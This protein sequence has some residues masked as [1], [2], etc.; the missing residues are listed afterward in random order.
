[1]RRP[2]QFLFAFTSCVLILL[3]ITAC[4][5]ITDAGPTDPPGAPPDPSARVALP[6]KPHGL[7]MLNPQGAD[8]ASTFLTPGASGFNAVKGATFQVHW[9]DIEPNEPGTWVFPTSLG[10]SVA[11]WQAAGKEVNLVFQAANYT[12]QSFM[13]AW[14]AATLTAA[15][16]QPRS[17]TQIRAVTAAPLGFLVGPAVGQYLLI[18]GTNT[19]LDNN[20]YPITSV[21]PSG[22]G[23][24]VTLRAPAAAT[25]AISANGSVGNPVFSCGVSTGIPAFWGPNFIHAWENVIDQVKAHLDDGS[26]GYL[27]IGMGLGGENSPVKDITACASTM[28]NL[29]FTTQPLPWPQY[30]TDPSAWESEVA[31]PW[32]MFQDTLI[33]YIAS[34]Q[35]ATPISF[36]LSPIVYAPAAEVD[37]A[38]PDMT[39]ALAVPAGFGIG[40]QGWRATD[41]VSGPCAG[42]YCNLFAQYMRRVPLELQST[43]ASTPK[44]VTSDNMTGSLAT[45]IPFAISVQ[46]QILE[47]YTDDWRCTF[48]PAFAGDMSSTPS[49]PAT[50][51]DCVAAGY[52]ATF[53]TAAQTLN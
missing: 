46:A 36:S 34:K 18:T 40:N 28:I 49:Y 43:L 4:S 52:P 13:P 17:S 14:Y 44:G 32:I 21:T 5:A 48:E 22:S 9:N 12:G 7:F 31:A 10:N 29:G 50:H 45:M 25:T 39:A 15:I 3:G 8:I 35:F 38:T 41:S 20:Q 42:D 24:V 6:G 30:S 53:A 33:Q 11:Q 16:T 27:R 1:M 37:Y 47:I 2:A 26:I 23:V 51:A 19:A